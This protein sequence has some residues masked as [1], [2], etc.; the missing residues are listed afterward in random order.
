MNTI[1]GGVLTPE[2]PPL[3]TP[4]GMFV[5]RT[6]SQLFLKLHNLDFVPHFE[7]ISET[8]ICQFSFVQNKTSHSLPSYTCSVIIYLVCSMSRFCG[9]VSSITY[10]VTSS[11][12]GYCWI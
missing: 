3:R 9:K 2:T 1:Q 5:L 10:N 4:M 12:N 11:R 7:T 6:K 8:E